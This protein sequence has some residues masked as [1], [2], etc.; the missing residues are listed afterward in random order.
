M[1][2]AEEY[3]WDIDIGAIAKIWRGGCIIRARFLNRIVDAYA[4]KPDL[5]TLLVGPYFAEAVASRRGSMAASRRARGSLRHPGPG[6]SSALA[7]F[8]CSPPSGS[9]P[10]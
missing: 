3:G 10:R 5:E 8:D 1:A 9:R 2:G 6:F 7:Y 4:N